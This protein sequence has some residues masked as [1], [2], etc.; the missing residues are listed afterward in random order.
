MTIVSCPSSDAWN[1]WPGPTPGGTVTAYVCIMAE[2]DEPAPL[3]VAMLAAECRPLK[4]SLPTP[5]S[6]GALALPQSRQD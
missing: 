5:V 4:A 1:C 6:Y 2:P 3:G